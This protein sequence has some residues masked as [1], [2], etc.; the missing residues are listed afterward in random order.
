M[1]KNMSEIIKNIL[2]KRADSSV[3]RINYNGISTEISS[4]KYHK[5]LGVSGVIPI[6]GAEEMLYKAKLGRTIN[7]F[8][9]VDE[10][11]KIGNIYSLANI[12]DPGYFNNENDFEEPMLDFGSGIISYCHDIRYLDN[13]K[14]VSLDDLELAIPKMHE[15]DDLKN[16]IYMRY[17]NILSEL[18]KSVL[19]EAKI[20]ISEITLFHQSMRHEMIEAMEF[21]ES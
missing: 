4:K 5:L 20:Q 16:A 2:S 14:D 8:S 10:N 9:L 11:I 19:F 17:R 15:E 13:Y 12:L 18:D 3:Y 1:L 7:H 21:I 6:N